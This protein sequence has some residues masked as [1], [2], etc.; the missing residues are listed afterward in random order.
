MISKP[1][2]MTEWADVR[3]PLEYRSVSSRAN[4]SVQGLGSMEYHL[5]HDWSARVSENSCR[6]T[7]SVPDILPGKDYNGHCICIMPSSTATLLA[8]LTGGARKSL[9]GIT[10]LFDSTE[11]ATRFLRGFGPLHPISGFL[12]LGLYE[13]MQRAAWKMYT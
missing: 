13:L 7:C 12:G 6:N 10:H 9:T 2:I 5:G 8:T 1:N 3:N 4:T 11:T